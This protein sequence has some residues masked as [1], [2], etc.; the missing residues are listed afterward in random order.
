LR[1]LFA[2][3]ALPDA[4]FTKSIAIVEMR[5]S[6]RPPR[7]VL[8][9]L[10]LT[11]LGCAVFQPDASKFEFQTWATRRS[12][13]HYKNAFLVKEF[14]VMSYSKSLK[15]SI[16]AGALALLHLS[17]V[18]PPS[19]AQSQAASDNESRPPKEVGF[20][21]NQLGAICVLSDEPGHPVQV[22][23]SHGRQQTIAGFCPSY[24]A[25]DGQVV[26]TRLLQLV[27][28]T[29]VPIYVERELRDAQV[30][31]REPRRDA[32][33]KVIGERIVALRSVPTEAHKRGPNDPH[34]NQ[35]MVLWID[36]T[37]SAEIWCDSRR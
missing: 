27:S 14:T 20:T 16:V 10:S 21:Q 11:V 4:H 8:V 7:I 30:L 1:A 34:K 2:C 13:L 36:G 3:E 5:R 37:Y 6:Y 29:Y 12:A 28:P 26:Y 35:G 9:R 32:N 31:I 17:L 25:T 33:A 18:S 24:T 23:D 22:K 15:P 19:F